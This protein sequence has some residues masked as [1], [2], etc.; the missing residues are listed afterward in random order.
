MRCRPRR[1]RALDLL[2]EVQR[3]LEERDGF[4]VPS[5]TTPLLVFFFFFKW[6]E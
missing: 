2:G 1:W 6:S 4:L 3:L 5:V